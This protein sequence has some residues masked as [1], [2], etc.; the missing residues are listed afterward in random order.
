VTAKIT[1]SDDI[2]LVAGTPGL[3]RGLAFGFLFSLPL[4]G[5]IVTIARWVF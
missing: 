2:D 4:W 5:A 1:T 3:A